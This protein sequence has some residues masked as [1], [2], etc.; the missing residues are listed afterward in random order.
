MFCLFCTTRDDGSTQPPPATGV[1]VRR[2]VTW[3]LLAVWVL[4]MSVGLVSAVH[5]KWLENWSSPGATSEAIAYKR[6]GDAFLHQREFAKAAAQYEKSLEIDPDQAP[7]MVNLAV[8]YRNLGMNRKSAEI[9]L[10]ASHQAGDEHGLVAFNL[11]ELAETAGK[12][13]QALQ[14]YRQAI[15]GLVEQDLVFRKIGNLLLQEGDYEGALEA[16]TN[17]LRVQIDD[18]RAYRNMLLR[19]RES[20]EDDS[21][22]LANIRAQLESG[23]GDEQLASYDLV[24]TERLRQRDPE[25]AKTHNHLGFIH[26]RLQNYDSAHSHFSRSLDIWPGNRDASAGLAAISQAGAATAQRNAKR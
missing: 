26:Y 18:G 17:C 19:A 1:S 12:N 16:Y 13:E 23:I 10:R 11:G 8:A 14:Y 9:L 25:I 20:F 3:L 21:L 15:G 6:Y 5:P 24:I 4:L 2:G 7:V 22:A